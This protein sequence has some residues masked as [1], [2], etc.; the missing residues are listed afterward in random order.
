MASAFAA[1]R[2]PRSSAVAFGPCLITS[3]GALDVAGGFESVRHETV[4]D[5]ALARRYRAAGRRVVCL[6]GADTVRFRM[7]PEGVRSLAR[8]W[9]KNLS[10]GARRAAIVPTLAAVLWVCGA[11]AVAAA[12]VAS[13]GWPALALW[14]AFATQSFWML[15]RLGAFRWWASVCF[16]IP[17]VAFGGL[18]VSSL[19][20]R[21]VRRSVAW[22]GRTIPIGKS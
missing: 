22:R 4:E 11:F 5:I 3:R 19:V 6:G 15:R 9:T 12:A 1:I 16:P 14:A 7:Y 18:F 8:G 21:G 10:G 13:P 17:L 20:A 2:A